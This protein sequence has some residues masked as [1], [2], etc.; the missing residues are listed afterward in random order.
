M[1]SRKPLTVKEVADYLHVGCTTVYRMAEQR[2]LPAYK[3]GGHWRF[4][5]GTI[6]NLS[7]SRQRIPGDKARGGCLQ[8]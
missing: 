7:F 4:D 6:W 2:Q 5:F 8:R 3:V 1:D